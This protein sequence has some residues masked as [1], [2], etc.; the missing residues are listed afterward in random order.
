MRLLAVLALGLALVS[1]GCFGGDDNGSGDNT[2][3]T[4]VTSTPATPTGSGTGSGNGTGTGTGSGGNGTGTGG[5]PAKPA[6][7]EVLNNAAV[8]FTKA[9]TPPATENVQT[10]NF[11]VPAGYT[12]L[13]LTVNW[14]T[15]GP[16]VLQNGVAV[17]ILGPDGS[18]VATCPGPAAGPSPAAPPGCTGEGTALPA[19]G[20][21]VAQYKGSGNLKA[22]VV[23]MAS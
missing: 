13:T 15:T 9:P 12:K 5:T 1:A 23:V 6:P 20:A 3:P 19:G 8:D 17:N 16:A 22:A 18:P 2:K 11:N 14:T 21:Y 4:P 10:E 7:A